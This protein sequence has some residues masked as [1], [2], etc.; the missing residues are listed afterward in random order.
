MPSNSFQRT[1][2]WQNFQTILKN[3]P[4]WLH[5]KARAT[6][7]TIIEQI[8]EGEWRA[9]FVALPGVKQVLRL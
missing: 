2:S 5:L 3:D 9:S 6:L 1:V 7:D 8:S 4:N